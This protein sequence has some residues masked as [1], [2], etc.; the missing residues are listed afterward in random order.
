MIA[1]GTA[2]SNGGKLARYMT[3]GKDG[4]RAEL[5]HL[6]GFASNDIT[7]AFRS[8]HLVAEGTKCEQPFF[9]VQVRNRNGETLT[10]EQWVHAADRIERM[11][12]LTGQPRAIAFHIDG[13][14]SH[15]H[16][17]IAFSRIDQDTLTAKPLPFFKER[18][19]KVSRELELHFGLEP[20]TS[21]RP[22]RIK[23]APSRAE[24]EQ[25]RRLGFDIHEVRR[26]I[27]ECWDRSDCG[28]GFVAALDDKGL[29][30]ARGDRRDFVVLDRAGGLHALGKR[31]LDA[32]KSAIRERLADLDTNHVPTVEKARENLAVGP[33]RKPERLDTLR[34]QLA[35]VNR[36]IYGPALD[37]LKHQLP[38][39]E[40]DYAQRDPV[41][42]DI[43]WHDAVAKAAIEKEKIE[44]RFVE[45]KDRDKETRAGGRGKDWPV[46]PE[47]PEPIETC[48]SLHVEDAAREATRP[49]PAPVIPS[50]LKGPAAD[51]WAAY[52]VRIHMQERERKN[53]EGEVEKYKVP[54]PVKAGRDP[55]QFGAALEQKGM[56]L[57][58]A[59]KDEA[60]HSRKEAEH[61]KTHGEWRPTYREGEIVVV[62][63]RGHVYS[64][65][66][67]TTGHDA[68]E[69]QS[70]LAKAEW[71]GLGGIAATK[72]AMQARA[73]RRDLDR[74]ALR[75][76]IAAARLKRAG[77]IK[78]PARTRGRN[79]GKAVRVA[80][81]V[82]A[83][84]V[85]ALADAFTNALE[86][87]L[88]PPETPERK[89]EAA[90]AKLERDADAALKK[91][92]FEFSSHLAA[93]REQE[94]HHTGQD[95]Y[96]K[97]RER[98][99]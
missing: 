69:V 72:E 80:R 30:L 56:V 19:K 52:N 21:R 57:A 15:E 11:L 82:P 18:L 79:V 25:A 86:S 76:E 47:R 39:A 70:F 41:R 23:Y 16:M 66:R 60:E 97:D 46:T 91:H 61:W 88:A 7:E 98:D 43:A 59:T 83:R 68:K 20:V 8:V 9:H 12:G 87:L 31:I 58:R 35:E 38:E 81:R 75:D 74:Q 99:R 34:Q 67:R 51:I 49:Q 4:E 10:R 6:R 44:R 85:G 62:T 50:N 71:K 5:W 77:T 64:L 37:Q 13:K 78:V 94:Q 22:D 32:N 28:R 93:L 48:P 45:P 14:T 63:Q 53:P 84:A 89:R 92:E 27:R 55:Y 65:N 73:S 2:H 29:I 95:N 26:N 96:R 17:H 90:A 40:R 24:E 1:K 3:T 36:E 54:I 33:Q 42:D